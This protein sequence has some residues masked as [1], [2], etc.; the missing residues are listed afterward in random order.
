ME[1]VVVEQRAVV[2]E[3]CPV[4]L[5]DDRVVGERVDERRDHRPE[6]EGAHPD[7]P[8]CD[9]RV[10]DQGLPLAPR[11][12]PAAVRRETSGAAGRRARWSTDVLGKRLGERARGVRRGRRRRLLPEPHRGESGRAGG[13]DSGPAFVNGVNV[14]CVSITT[15]ALTCGF[16]RKALVLRTRRASRRRAA[17]QSTS[18]FGSVTVRTKAHAASGFFEWLEIESE[19]SSCLDARWPKNF[20]SGALSH[21]NGTFGMY[22]PTRSRSGTSRAAAAEELEPVPRGTF[23][24]GAVLSD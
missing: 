12:E 1:L 21:W 24:S 5:R 22:S 19:S 10:R 14:E 3:P 6:V 23:G 4:G 13:V 9:E 7:Q 17:V 20:G 15:V 16:A 11:G 18:A 2:R 8:R